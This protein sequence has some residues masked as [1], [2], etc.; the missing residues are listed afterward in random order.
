MSYA[1]QNRIDE[2]E[3]KKPI[4][5]HRMSKWYVKCKVKDKGWMDLTA[6][7]LSYRQLNRL[8]DAT[9]VIKHVSDIH[10]VKGDYSHIKFQRIDGLED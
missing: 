9:G 7:A 1:L 10:E 5:Q 8:I 2:N 3:P 6:Y 4:Q